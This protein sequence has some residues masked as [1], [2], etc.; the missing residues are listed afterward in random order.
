MG[1]FFN[2]K[3]EIHYPCPA[4]KK[5][6][7]Y[8][9]EGDPYCICSNC[10]A[11]NTENSIADYW[12]K[13]WRRQEIASKKHSPAFYLMLREAQ[14]KGDNRKVTDGALNPLDTMIFQASI[15]P[16]YCEKL[17]AYENPKVYDDEIYG[18]IKTTIYNSRHNQ[19]EDAMI[20]IHANYSFYNTSVDKIHT[21]KDRVV[22]NIECHSRAE[23]YRHYWSNSVD[24]YVDINTELSQEA[25]NEI[26]DVIKRYCE[27]AINQDIS[28]YIECQIYKYHENYYGF[29]DITFKE[30]ICNIS[31]KIEIKYNVSYPR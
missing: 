10:N 24:H 4:C 9:T 28:Y 8:Y 26:F 29:D 23:V 20:D 2:K 12:N 18:R 16:T 31:H 19:N 11:A 14:S 15:A 25:K 30:V 27:K 3:R 13:E 21:T 1:L 6:P 22:L 7:V 5:G 17:S